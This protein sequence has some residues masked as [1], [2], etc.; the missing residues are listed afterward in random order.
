MRVLRASDAK[1][2]A[3][4]A[5]D[6]YSVKKDTAKSKL[7]AKFFELERER[8]ISSDMARQI[9]IATMGNMDIPEFESSLLLD[10]F[11]S[12]GQLF[13]ASSAQLYQCS[14]LVD[15]ETVDKL[16][17]LFCAETPTLH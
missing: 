5:I 8:A 1:S 10:Q 16:V 11:P 9:V 2:A 13:T 6:C 17:E 14:D 4:L 7:Q 12:I 15:K 3:Q